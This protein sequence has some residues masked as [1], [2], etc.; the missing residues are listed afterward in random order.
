MHRPSL[1]PALLRRFQ[2]VAES[3]ETS[4]HERDSFFGASVQGADDMPNYASPDIPI[5]RSAKSGGRVALL[6]KK[7]VNAYAEIEYV[8]AHL[9]E[10]EVVKNTARY[11][12]KSFNRE[13]PPL[14]NGDPDLGN[15][16]S[17][18]LHTY[19]GLLTSAYEAIEAY[20]HWLRIISGAE[21]AIVDG[22]I[23]LVEIYASERKVAG[24]D[25]LKNF[26]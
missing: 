8:Q 11:A 26:M 25:S 12:V 23:S 7:E 19:L 18:D 17:E 22:K 20:I 4:R 24:G 9:E 16:S 2:V 21:S 14:P 10:M 3:D 15:A 5:W 13:F 6:T 1:Y